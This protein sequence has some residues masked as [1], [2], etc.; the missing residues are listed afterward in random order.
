MPGDDR[1]LDVVHGVGNVVGEVHDLRFQAGAPLRG[2]LA[3]PVEDRQVVLVGAELAGPLA[4]DDGGVRGR[5]RVLRCGVEARPGQVQA[6]R[7]AVGGDDLGFQPGQQPQRLGVAFEAADR[8]GDLV[9]GR[10][11]VVAERRVAKV[12]AEARG[13]HD[14]RVAAQGAAQFAAHL[15]HLEAVGEA[16]PD[17]VVGVRGHDL[18]L[19]PEP[20]QGRGVQHAGAVA[21]E[22]GAVRGLGRF[23]HPAGGVAGHIAAQH[24]RGDPGFSHRTRPVPR[25][26]SRATARRPC[27]G[28]AAS[29]WAGRVSWA[30]RRVRGGPRHRRRGTATQGPAGPG[31][32][33][34]TSRLV[35]MASLV[36]S[37]L[38]TT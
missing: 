29:P 33:R 16:G 26:R 21:F 32:P 27:C 15:G 17:E 37:S 30:N 24:G 25:G 22:V 18:G 12:V 19:G 4:M 23:L 31:V 7:P 2:V 13:V 6:G 11:A 5:P 36:R 14:I 3:D 8:V 35:T 34:S 10:F 20:A 9:Q 1:V 38:P 28:P